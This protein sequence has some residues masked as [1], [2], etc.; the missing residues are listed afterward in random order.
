MNKKNYIN[1]AK[2]SANIQ[3]KELKKINKVF[4]N[5]FVKAVDSILNC[6]GKVVLGGIGKSGLIARKISATFSSVGIPSFFCYPA[7]ALH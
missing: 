3:I 6:K 7:Q 2:K 5:S 4:N 1:L